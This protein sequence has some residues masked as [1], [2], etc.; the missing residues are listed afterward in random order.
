[1]TQHKLITRRQLLER[2]GIVSGGVLVS[3]A[4][5]GSVAREA[6]ALAEDGPGPELAA[7]MP[8]ACWVERASASPPCHLER[9]ARVLA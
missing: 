1:M 8:S 6:S 2:S 9:S 3:E 7:A 4:V 5:L